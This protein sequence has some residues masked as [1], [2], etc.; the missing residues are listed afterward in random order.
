MIPNDL[1]ARLR[2]L[3][4]ASFFSKEPPQVG[5][6]RSSSEV[7]EDLPEFL[8]GQRIVATIREARADDSFRALINGREYTLTLPRHNA[9]AGQ[10][11]DL[12]VT[13]ATPRGVLAAVTDPAGAAVSAQLSQTGRLISF[14]LT[15]QPTAGAAQLA[16]GQPV[17]PAPPANAAQVLPLLRQAVG[18]SGLFY[19]AQ[20]ARW[21]AGAVSTESLLRQPQSQ[22]SR[23]RPA[24]VAGAAA[25]SAAAAAATAAPRPPAGQAGASTS[26]ALAGNAVEL[27]EA[28]AGS[29]ARRNPTPATGTPIPE[30]LLPIVHQQ[31]DALAT[32][33]YAWQGT[34]WPGQSMHWEIEEP[35]EGE[36]GEQSDE[37]WKTSLRLTLP[38]LGGIEARLHL[39]RAGVALRLAAAEPGTVA[40]MAAA[41]QSLADALA[42]A[43]VPLTGMSVEA[44]GKGGE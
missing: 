25:S 27:A 36:A 31:L 40:A 34:I 20:L 24:S 32:H 29:A 7:S 30:R 38:R 19:E 14:L 8:P 1:A 28:N 3:T 16:A 18:E 12:I 33:Q 5:A 39:T 37:G 9:R 4:E 21:L 26:G 43:G 2:L 23:A 22:L 35:P 15:G 42:A 17:L 44:G 41:R 6:L 10:T 13:H 11:L